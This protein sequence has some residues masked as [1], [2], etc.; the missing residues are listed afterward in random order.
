MID[1][2]LLTTISSLAVVVMTA[3]V[4]VS[5]PRDSVAPAL[6]EVSDIEIHEIAAEE[7]ER[8][9]RSE[10]PP[11]ETTQP[12]IPFAGYQYVIREHEGRIAVFIP[13]SDSPQTVL[14]IQ[15]RHLPPMERAHMEAGVPARDYEHLVSLLED[16]TS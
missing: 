12:D 9:I 1:R 10:P 11:G 7:P 8:I 2:K 4:A 3:V 15:V 16:Y 5:F 6:Q 13:G 14:D